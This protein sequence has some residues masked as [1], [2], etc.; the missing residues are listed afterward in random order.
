[1]K[2]H[3]S[4]ADAPTAKAEEDAMLLQAELS[5]GLTQQIGMHAHLANQWAA[6]LTQY[7]RQRLGSQRIYIP[8]PS[9][10]ERDAAIYR[11]HDGTNTAALCRRYGITRS[12]LY[13]IVEDQRALHRAASPL[14]CSK[15]GQ[16][17]A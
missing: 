15:T 9:K 2:D 6:M 8:A 4:N 7:L 5:A 12:R 11:E 16:T 14:F 13:K 1:M 10:A 3:N 17:R